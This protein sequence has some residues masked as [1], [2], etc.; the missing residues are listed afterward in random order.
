[1]Y[2]VA[3]ERAMQAELAAGPRRHRRRLAHQ[4]RPSGAASAMP[5]PPTRS[6]PQLVVYPRSGTRPR[7]TLQLESRAA[8]GAR[9]QPA[10]AHPAASEE[11]RR[12]GAALG[13]D[14]R[15][16]PADPLEDVDS[17]EAPTTRSPMRASSPSP[18]TST[19]TCWSASR[20]PRSARCNG[21]CAATR[22]QL[23]ASVNAF[24][25]DLAASG[26]AGAADAGVLRRHARA[27]TTRSRA[28]SRPTSPTA[29]RF[30]APGSSRP[31]RALGLDWRLLA[32]V[33]YQESK[34]DPHA[35]LR[36]RRA[37]A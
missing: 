17:G 3:N 26:R 13:G 25:R 5:P 35:Q 22:P 10:G 24:F 12:A 16:A 11:H 21:S 9:R 33:G 32:A 30:T 31:P 8:R 4:H 2:P 7:D 28:S 6:I 15:R 20:C 23:L 18:I 34:W 27:S 19:P 1:M 37:S 36:R 14:R 29:C